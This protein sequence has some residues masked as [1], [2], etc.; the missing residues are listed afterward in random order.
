M[1]AGFR[2]SIRNGGRPAER[3]LKVR[4]EKVRVAASGLLDH[5][6]LRVET[7]IERPLSRRYWI[8]LCPFLSIEVSIAFFSSEGAEITS[9]RASGLAEKI[10][11]RSLLRGRLYCVGNFR[12]KNE[13]MC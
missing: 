12:G 5:E 13:R 11:T 2:K 10:F 9:E 7:Y 3:V 1:L 8:E 6:G 4:G